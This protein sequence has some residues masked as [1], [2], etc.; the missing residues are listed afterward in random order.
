VQYNPTRESRNRR[1]QVRIGIAG[2]VQHAVS[3][4]I[5]ETSLLKSRY[6][7]KVLADHVKKL[8]SDLRRL[9]SEESPDIVL[10]W[11]PDSIYN[12][13]ADHQAAADAVRLGLAGERLVFYGTR[14]PNL[15]IGFGAEALRL[16][17]RSL[18]AHRLTPSAS[19]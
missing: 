10:S 18:R 7:N 6:T 14:K 12:P 5:R 4:P 19:G 3:Q 16:K 17:L 15:W 9:V 2:A 8:A 13:H 11:D 1:A